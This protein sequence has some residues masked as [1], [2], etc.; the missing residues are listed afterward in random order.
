[1]VV[2]A[3]ALV[4]VGDSDAGG[5]TVAIAASIKA[6]PTGVTPGLI[7]TTPSGVTT[8]PAVWFKA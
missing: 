3:V 8:K 5:V 6:A 1:M 7:S 4:G 2:V